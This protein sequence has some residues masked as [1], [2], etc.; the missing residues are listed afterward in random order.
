[1]MST[2]LNRLF[3]V[4]YFPLMELPA[5]LMAGFSFHIPN[6][7]WWDSLIRWLF[8]VVMLVIV[9][10]IESYTVHRLFKKSYAFIVPRMI[11]I[12]GVELVV[13]YFARELLYD[14]SLMLKDNVALLFGIVFLLVLLCVRIAI[15]VLAFGWFDPSVGRAKLIKT[16]LYANLLSQLFL[17]VITWFFWVC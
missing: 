15:S 5:R 8:V 12:N 14:F 6:I 16:M 3:A 13:Q 11:V 1:M 9:V 2:I 7:P 4:L 17:C 10:G